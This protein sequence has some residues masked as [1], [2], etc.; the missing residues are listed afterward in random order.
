MRPA[1][2]TALTGEARGLMNAAVEATVTANMKRMGLIP[3]PFWM[4]AK[5]EKVMSMT[6]VLFMISV[7][8]TVTVTRIKRVMYCCPGLSINSWARPWS[9]VA[10][11]PS[12]AG[13]AGWSP[14]LSRRMMRVTTMS[15]KVRPKKGRSKM[16]L[17]GDTNDVSLRFLSLIPLMRRRPP[18]SFER[19]FQDLE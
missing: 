15:M 14:I 9:Q 8:N 5:R 3:E 11:K 12:M 17:R 6:V 16:S 13:V 1:K 4:V 2:A 10:M 7:R 18:E 19:V